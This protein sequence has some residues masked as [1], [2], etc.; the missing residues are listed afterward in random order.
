VNY[1]AVPKDRD[2]LRSVCPV[3]ASYGAL[4]RQFA[5]HARRLE[6]HLEA[7]GVPHDIE[8][9]EGVGHSFMSYDNAPAWM[10]R[11]NTRMGAGYRETESEDSW[12]RILAFFDEHVTA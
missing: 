12:R 9:Y 1:G 5:S 6:E 10:L 11:L 8:T 2:A 3:V 7:L 4:D